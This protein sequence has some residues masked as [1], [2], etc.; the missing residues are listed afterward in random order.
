MWNNRH[1]LCRE[2]DGSNVDRDG[3]LRKA[4]QRHWVLYSLPC[5][6]ISELNKWQ[7]T[8]MHLA[9]NLIIIVGR[10]NSR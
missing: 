3:I 1:W 5:P 7:C 8:L 2:D 4:G 6:N 9:F 10:P